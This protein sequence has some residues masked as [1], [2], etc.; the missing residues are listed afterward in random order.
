MLIFIPEPKN[1]SCASCKEAF[2]ISSKVIFHQL[3][4]NP[5]SFTQ[6]VVKKPVKKAVKVSTKEP[7]K[8]QAK[9]A[10]KEAAKE[11][12]KL[13]KEPVKEAAKVPSKVPTKVPSKIPAKLPSKEASKEAVKESAQ[14]P[15]KESGR[16]YL[17]EPVKEATKE[18]ARENA[19]LPIK[20]S[21]NEAAKVPSKVFVKVPAKLPI[22]EPAKEAVKENVQKPTKEPV[23]ETSILTSKERLKVIIK[24]EP[25]VAN[26]NESQKMAAPALVAHPRDMLVDDDSQQEE[27]FL[28]GTGLQMPDN[29]DLPDEIIQEQLLTA[30]CTS[31][32]IRYAKQDSDDEMGD[33]T[34]NKK[35]TESEVGED[36][37]DT[38]NRKVGEIKRKR[39][40]SEIDSQE[41]LKSQK[42]SL[43][44]DLAAKRQRTVQKLRNLHT[45]ASRSQKTTL[46]SKK[47]TKPKPRNDDSEDSDS[48]EDC[49][50]NYRQKEKPLPTQPR[51]STKMRVS[52]QIEGA[53]GIME[54]NQ[55]RLKLLCSD[56]SETDEEEKAEQRKGKK[57]RFKLEKVGKRI[58]RMVSDDSDDP[59]E[60]NQGPSLP[61]KKSP[62]TSTKEK[63]FYPSI[64]LAKLP[65]M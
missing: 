46:V 9:E 10:A 64:T 62:E 26:E 34:Q 54:L 21:A 13:P 22:K 31:T 12:A 60:Q 63:K 42:F 7:G 18:A 49:P 24:D 17:K 45:P 6:P 2:N 38:K 59:N 50:K 33:W 30:R 61:E 25:K 36:N 48:S 19:K 32:P 28:S 16:E 27:K 57:K 4:C 51:T 65:R 15:T 37:E 40:A 1:H 39:T 14:K 56:S 58:K 41:P 47:R 20:E 11:H 23:I 3:Q 44:Q 53:E 52:V 5:R 29:F 8:E 55:Y 43:A 35:T